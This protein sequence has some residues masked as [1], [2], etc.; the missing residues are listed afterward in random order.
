MREAEMLLRP[1]RRGARTAESLSERRGKTRLGVS[2]GRQLALRRDLTFRTG[3][4]S[5]DFRRW[6][7]E[8]WIG[9]RN[10]APPLACETVHLVRRL[11]A[12]AGTSTTEPPPMDLR[13]DETKALSPRSARSAATISHWPIQRAVSGLNRTFKNRAN[14]K[15]TYWSRLLTE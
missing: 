12:R 14:F 11:N 6:S 7:R 9:S 1:P 2:E 3:I 10:H 13:G 15:L 4:G 5:A 8:V